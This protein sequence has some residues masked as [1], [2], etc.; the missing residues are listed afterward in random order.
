MLS[1]LG[2]ATAMSFSE[3]CCSDMSQE[4]KAS[5]ITGAT[6]IAILARNA[7]AKN[8][9]SDGLQKFSYV[10][11]RCISFLKAKLNGF[12]NGV[13]E[14]VSIGRNKILSFHAKAGQR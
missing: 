5:L 4:S 8:L 6:A 11:L 9:V 14:N 3:S 13:N 10:P 7:T 1:A 2:S 12:N